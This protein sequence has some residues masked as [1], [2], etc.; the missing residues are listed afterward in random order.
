MRFFALISV[1][2]LSAAFMGCQLRPTS[3]EW[4]G[5]ENGSLEL[6]PDHTYSL[7]IES[8]AAMEPSRAK[9]STFGQWR[10]VG[11]DLPLVEL[12]PG[13]LVHLASHDEGT[14]A[15]HVTPRSTR[16][17]VSD[18]T[19]LYLNVSGT[20]ELF[21]PQFAVTPGGVQPAGVAAMLTGTPYNYRQIPNGP[22]FHDLLEASLAMYV[23]ERGWWMPCTIADAFIVSQWSQIDSEAPAE[24]AIENPVHSAAIPFSD[25]FIL[26]T[27]AAAHVKNVTIHIFHGKD[28][29]LAEW[30]RPSRTPKEIADADVMKATITKLIGN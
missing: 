25:I 27:G 20:G 14:S 28:V 11:H 6:H 17:P 21:L 4:Y 13:S 12:I 26:R 22:I 8:P 2:G 23:Q 10:T 24:E 3:W 30:H 9:P 5:P 19:L 1:L 16:L 18:D 7:K 29:A 15:F